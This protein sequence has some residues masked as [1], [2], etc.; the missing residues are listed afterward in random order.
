MLRNRRTIIFTLVFPAALFFAI[1][2]GHGLARE[3]RPRQRR[4]VHHGLDGAVRRRA[5]R[6]LAGAMVA[7]ERALGWSRQLRLT[8][9]NP[10]VYILH[11]GADRPGPRARS[12]S[13]W[14]TWSAIV[15]GKADDAGR[16]SGS[17]C[18]LLTL[19]CTM[20]FAALGVFVGYLVPGENAMQILGPGL[21]LLSFLGNVFIPIDQTAARCGTSPHWT[22]MFGVAE[23]SPR[24]AHRRP[25][26]VRRA[27][28]PW[29]G[30]R[31]SSPAPP[32]G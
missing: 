21:A 32:G 22:P 17:P 23:I 11:E 4:G 26:V 28:T 19:V 5:D 9:L 14:S 25:A 27:S 13:R 3:G 12:R 10:A 16:T 30:S 6:R 2:S 20:V 24:P 29:S 31:S 18:A 8:P 7:I 1:G 15:Q